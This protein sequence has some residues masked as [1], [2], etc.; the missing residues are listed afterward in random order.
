MLLVLIGTLLL[1][2][3]DV[4][5]VI[6][7]IH[8]IVPNYKAYLLGILRFYLNLHFLLI[9]YS[10]LEK[11]CWKWKI[12]ISSYF[13]LGIFLGCLVGEG[14]LD[15]QIVMVSDSLYG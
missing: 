8:E 2:G 6:F 3:C 1:T 7:V 12:A 11:L 5:V 15:E 9:A 4:E 13:C 14:F 10:F